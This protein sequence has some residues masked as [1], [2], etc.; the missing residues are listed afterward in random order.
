MDERVCA[1]KEAVRV[2]WRGVVVVGV[3]CGVVGCGVGGW[4]WGGGDGDGTR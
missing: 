1:V 4:W 2:V 3:W